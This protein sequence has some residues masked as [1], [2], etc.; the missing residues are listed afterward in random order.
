MPLL[1]SGGAE[2][3]SPTQ[4]GE[5]VRTATGEPIEDTRVKRGTTRP[6]TRAGRFYLNV[7]GWFLC[8]VAPE[9]QRALTSAVGLTSGGRAAGFPFP[10]GPLFARQTVRYEVRP[11]ARPGCLRQLRRVP[12]GERSVRQQAHPR[13]PA[14]AGRAGRHLGV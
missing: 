6:G 5:A 12:G 1:T 4:V 9:Q 7:T 11:L 2:C 13:S 3:R 8:F 14:C 10:L